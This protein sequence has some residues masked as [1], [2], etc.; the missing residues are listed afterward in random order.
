MVYQRRYYHIFAL[1]Y[2]VQTSNLQF[3]HFCHDKVCSLPMLRCKFFVCT[4]V[5]DDHCLTPRDTCRPHLVARGPFLERP[6]NLTGPKAYFEIKVSRKVGS[7]MT[8]NEVQFVP[9]ANN[10]TVQFSNLLKLPSG[11]EIKTA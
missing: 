1:A 10:F 5:T 11:M 2:Q 4:V 7:V 8:S 3:C 6:G 9:L